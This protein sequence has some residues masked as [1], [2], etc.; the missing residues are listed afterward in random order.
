MIN[1]GNKIHQVFVRDFKFKVKFRLPP[2]HKQC[3]QCFKWFTSKEK[4]NKHFK[5]LHTYH[6]K[7]D[8]CNITFL[9]KTTFVNHYKKNHRK[10]QKIGKKRKLIVQNLPDS[11]NQKIKRITEQQE[12]EIKYYQ[13]SNCNIDF[14]KLYELETHVKICKY[15]NKSFSENTV[16][17]K[18]HNFTFKKNNGRSPLHYAAEKGFYQVC[19]S[20]LENLCE[21]SPQDVTWQTPL[22]L[23]AKNGHTE[24]Y[25]LITEG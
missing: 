6:A 13:C 18:S 14:A 5:N 2:N 3:R 25:Q 24:V 15:K 9:D 8:V 1:L 22:H 19:K 21:K 20:I 23:A 12:I 10:P 4:K 16:S 17:A 7:C 11:N